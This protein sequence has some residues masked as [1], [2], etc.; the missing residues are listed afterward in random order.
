MSVTVVIPMRNADNFI[1]AALDSVCGNAL[2]RQIIVV[3]DYSTDCSAE[4]VADY[5]AKDSRVALFRHTQQKGAGAARNTGFAFAE[6]KYCI[7][8]DA[9]DDLK[10]KALDGCAAVLDA[11]QADFLVFKWYYCDMLGHCERQRMLEQDENIWQSITGGSKIVRA[12][13]RAHPDILR[14]ANFPWHKL[15]STDFLRRAGIHFSETLVHNDNLA[16]WMSYVKSGSFILYDEYLIGHREDKS[17]KS[18]TQIWDQR[19][20]QLFNVFDEVDNFLLSE[21][22]YLSYFLQFVRYKAQMIDWV[23]GLIDKALLPLFAKKAV[24]TFAMLNFQT[25]LFVAASDIVAAQRI[26]DV[27][28]DV[29]GYLRKIRH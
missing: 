24:R 8:L 19:R 28:H 14:T 15:Y 7:F 9:D 1:E 21:E 26:Y 6:E 22:A 10:P 25:F 11:Y 29:G 20:L 3:D 12:D 2:V 13:I 18:L 27:I 4:K 16:H 23:G 5:A 17:K